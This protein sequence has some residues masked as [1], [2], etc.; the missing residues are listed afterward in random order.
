MVKKFLSFLKERWITVP[1]A[2]VIV[3]PYED[4]DSKSVN[5]RSQT[6]NRAIGKKAEQLEA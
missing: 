2:T 6:D 4:E 5:Q 1:A 3:L